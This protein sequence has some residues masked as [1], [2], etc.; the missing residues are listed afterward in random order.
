MPKYLG[1]PGTACDGSEPVGIL[2]VNSGT[3]DSARVRDIRRFLGKLLG[4]PRVVEL[5]RWLW[6]PILHGLILPLRPLRSA[7]KY[8]D[9]LAAGRSPLRALSEALRTALE[10]ELVRQ[11]GA[12]A[13]VEAGMLYSSPSVRDA[14]LRLV[15]RGARRVLVVPLFPQ[16]CGV[17][18]GAVIDA[19]ARVLGSLR[20]VPEV[21]F[22]TDYHDH[23][24]HIEALRASIAAHWAA[25][26]RAGHL[27]MS[28]H[29]VPSA[30]CAKGDPYHG[31]CHAT[32]QL[33]ADALGLREGEWSV[34]FQSRF[35]GGRWLR[36]YTADVLEALP[37]RGV[38]TATVVCPGFAIDCLETLQ[39]IEV[40]NRARFLRAGGTKLDYVPALN[41]RPEHVAALARLIG[42]H[43]RG[44]VDRAGARPSGSFPRVVSLG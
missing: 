6:L 31:R 40:E 12:P 14:I 9:M 22:V 27:L 39:E 42:T 38:H 18:T 28:W 16:Y 24:D 41:S 19:V 33:L 43:A 15:E 21:R 17:T 20:S 36:P 34:A 1:T 4:D 10:Q 3:P 26:G 37:S 11:S 44:W 13:C 30:Y 7:R 25:H 5:P 32:A 8:R 23:D 35:G 29:G 2:L